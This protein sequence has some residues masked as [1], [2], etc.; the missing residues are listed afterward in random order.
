[1]REAPSW[2]LQE[3][4]A[5]LPCSQPDRLVDSQAGTDSD[6]LLHNVAV[7]TAQIFRLIRGKQAQPPIETTSSFSQQSGTQH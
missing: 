6:K 1:M 3:S 5:P 4:V 2:M 7:V